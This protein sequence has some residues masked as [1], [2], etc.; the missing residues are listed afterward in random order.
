MVDRNLPWLLLA[1]MV[2]TPAVAEDAAPGPFQLKLSGFA[3]TAIGATPLGVASASEAEIEA[4]PQYKLNRRVTL[5]ARVVVNAGAFANSVDDRARLSLPEISA[6]AIGPWGRIEVGRRAGFPQSLIGFTP[7]EIA[8]TV[9]EYGPESGARLDP[10][11]RLVTA[12][13]PEALRGPIDRLTYL[14]Y[15]ARLYDDRSAKIIYL[16]PRFKGGFYGA[17]SYTP[18]TENADDFR[19]AGASQ[20]TGTRFRDIVQAALVWNRR[21]ETLDLSVGGTVSHATA[22]ASPVS[23]SIP[24]K[25]TSLSGGVSATIRDRWALGLSGTWDGLSSPVRGAYGVVASVNYV[26]GPWIAGG[27]VQ[28]AEVPR[29]ATPLTGPERTEAV[30]LAQLGVSYFADQDHDLLGV[31]FYTDV[32]LFASVIAFSLRASDAN[33]RGRQDGAV[34][35]GGVRFAFF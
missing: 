28:H 4:S 15:A 32:K 34:V 18:R 35:L 14:G 33:A 5:A 6:F 31:G 21:S 27:Y 3:N 24:R 13:L 12:L 19:L 23:N 26:A 17:V 2:A 29:L 7:S 9:A 1:A 8:F 20:T 11:G 10:D 30:D 16:S 22:V 25:V